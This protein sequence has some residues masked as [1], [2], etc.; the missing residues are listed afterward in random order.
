MT[1]GRVEPL[2]LEGGQRVKTFSIRFLADFE[3]AWQKKGKAVLLTLA[4]K[5]PEAFFGGAVALAKVVKWD[6]A[7][8][9]MFDQSMTPEQIMDKL[10]SSVWGRKVEGCSSVSCVT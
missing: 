4:D 5:R 7:D 6:Q 8:A 3:E 9:S 10:G 1:N 2:L